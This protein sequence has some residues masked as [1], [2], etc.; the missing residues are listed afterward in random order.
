MASEAFTAIDFETANRDR[1]SACSIGLVRVE[2]GHI[3]ER[4]SHLIRPP[5]PWFEFSSLH[6]ITWQQVRAEP[7]FGALWPTLEPF[8]EG[9][10]FVAAHNASFDA[11]VLY[12]CC[13]WAGVPVPQVR[14]VCTVKLARQ[15]W[16]IRPTRLPN[17]ARY[18]GLPH[19]HHDAASD[20]EVCARIVLR[21][22]AD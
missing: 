9:V 5:S 3:V 2:K 8:F 4:A 6:G 17:V 19:E 13:S 18:L 1:G 10:D 20:A 7:C 16:K 14:F 22:H 11:S 21:A 12:A 15:R